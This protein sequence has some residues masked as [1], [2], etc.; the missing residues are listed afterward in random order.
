MC[1]RGCRS[2]TSRR[3]ELDAARGTGFLSRPGMRVHLGGIGKGYAVDRAAAILRADGIS[4][5]LIQAGG[6]LYASG[7]RGDRPWRAGIRDPRGPVDR[8]FAAM[9]LRDETFSTS[10]DYER[11]FIRDGRRYHHILDP[12]DGRAGARLPKRDDR[13]QAARSWPTRCPPACSCSDLRPGWR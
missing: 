3:V 11:Y 2:S 1:A 4:D 8:I 5:F 6:D 7:T 9:D 12:D 13:G 10:G